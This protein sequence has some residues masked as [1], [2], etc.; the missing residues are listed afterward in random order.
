MK[1]LLV[2]SLFS[3]IFSQNYSKE[4]GYK[5]YSKR[6]EEAVSQGKITRE[7]A[8]ERY[9]GLEKRLKIS[10][11]RGPRSNEISMRFERLGINNLDKIKTNLINE[12][13]TDL[14][15]ESVLG[16][17]IRVIHAAK[18]NRDE[19]IFNPKMQRYFQNDCGLSST[20]ID[21]IKEL[22][23]DLVQ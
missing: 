4:D 20:Q 6:I 18:K 3:L 12:G 1:R 23:I 22:S 9:R 13:V 21:Y 11:K 17:M 19:F 16:G 5:Q 2:F 15:M 10:G 7:Q 8:N 14:Q